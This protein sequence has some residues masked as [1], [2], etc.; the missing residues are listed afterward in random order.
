MT[1]AKLEL[2]CSDLQE[3]ARWRPLQ[4]K[5]TICFVCICFEEVLNSRCGVLLTLF[6]IFFT[7]MLFVML[8]VLLYFF[9]L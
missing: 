8:F 5:E 1:G 9:E 2:L 6:N 4:R 3:N 7:V